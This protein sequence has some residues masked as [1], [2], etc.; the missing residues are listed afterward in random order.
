[1]AA[2]STG[3][4]S[5]AVI[6]RPGDWTCPG[7]KDLQF[8]RNLK[9]RRCGTLQPV[10]P[11]KPPPLTQGQQAAWKDWKPGMPM[12]GSGGASSAS[13]PAPMPGPVAPGPVSA[14][15]APL[16][17][18]AVGSS[19]A[20]ASAALAASADNWVCSCCGNSQGASSSS[21]L[22]CASPRPAM[23]ST[24]QVPQTMASAI[25]VPALA[26]PPAAMAGFGV[27][28]ASMPAT[29]LGLP[30]QG[31]TARPSLAEISPELSQLL[32]PSPGQALGSTAA[33]A[34]VAGSGSAGFDPTR[35]ASTV[36]IDNIPDTMEVE[37]LVMLFT[38][39]FGSV[40]DQVIQP[41]PM[42]PRRFATLEF[43]SSEGVQRAITQARFQFGIDEL[44]IRPSTILVPAEAGGRSRGAGGGSERR[45]RSP[46]RW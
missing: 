35:L 17:P 32:L 25:A 21:C 13:L 39:M 34:P 26:V 29:T 46:K 37:T 12:P 6:G 3:G 33:V 18:G 4:K 7:C 42:L 22:L 44:I 19:P 9:C 1:M 2:M 15:A 30:G 38:C 5:G 23:G 43:T 28:P 31:S 11:S 40:K 27:S 16:P 45:S 14:S 10:A 36:R 41:D 24:P 8:A 20:P